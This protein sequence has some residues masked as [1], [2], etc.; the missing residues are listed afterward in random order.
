MGERHVFEPTVRYTDWQLDGDAMAH[1][2]PKLQMTYLYIT[3]KLV[4]DANLIWQ[5][6]R[7]DAVHPVYGKTLDVDRY[8]LAVTAF[9]DLFNS[10]RWRAF[11]SVDLFRDHANIAFF[12]SDASMLLL[13]AIWRHRRK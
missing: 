3:P 7:S 5:T 12:D 13:G 1:A 9:Y 4:I 8:G 11:A 10:K 2:G 6:Y